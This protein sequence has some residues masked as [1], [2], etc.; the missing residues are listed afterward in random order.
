[1]IEKSIAME[2]VLK[3]FS[4]GYAHRLVEPMKDRLFF[5]PEATG[6]LGNIIGFISGMWLAGQHEAAN[7][8]ADDFMKWLDYLCPLHKAAFN[9][10]SRDVAVPGRVCQLH[11]DGTVMGFS[12]AWYILLQDQQQLEPSHKIRPFGIW[13]AKYIYQMNGGLLFHGSNQE[14]YA[15]NLG[16]NSLWGIHT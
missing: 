6:T 7:K 9:I 3:A 11:S 12:L 14:N 10:G 1:M 15:V 5:S 4:S 2:L 16:N 8:Y 13:D